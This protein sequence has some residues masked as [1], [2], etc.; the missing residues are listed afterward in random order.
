[1]KLY[2]SSYRIPEPDELAVLLTKPIIDWR[3]AIIPNAK[4]YE[5]PHIRAQKLDELAA[6]LSK[7]GLASTIVDLR[8]Y[9]DLEMLRNELKTHDLFW[10]AGGNTFVLRFEMHRS[11]FDQ[12][13]QNL[14]QEERVYGGESAGAIVAGITLEGFEIGDDPDL[15]EEVYWDGLGVVEKIIAPH[16]DSPDFI[17]YINH[18]KKVYAGDG[19]VIY[20][21]DDQAF[22]VNGTEQKIVT[23]PR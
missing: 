13:I 20:L 4:D 23:A 19:R 2:L 22:V 12:I 8:D 6:D 15:A 11:G 1:V 21:N 5:L 14:L 17:E 7:L 10:V 16:M 18:I 3:V 9:D